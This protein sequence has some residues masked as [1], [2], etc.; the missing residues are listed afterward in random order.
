MHTKHY[1]LLSLIAFI[2]VGFLF[3]RGCVHCTGRALSG[4]PPV[5]TVIVEPAK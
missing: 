4:D 2:V 1:I 3:V 5:Q